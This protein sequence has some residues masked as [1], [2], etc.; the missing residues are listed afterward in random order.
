MEIYPAPLVIRL[1]LLT[2]AIGFVSSNAAA[3]RAWRPVD[4]RVQATVVR[5]IDTLFSGAYDQGA[6][7]AEVTSVDCKMRDRSDGGYVVFCSA[8]IEVQPLRQSAYGSTV[9]CTALRYNVAADLKSAELVDGGQACTDLVN[10]V[11]GQ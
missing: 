5:E 7:E 9:C 6:G 10:S 11:K 8:D 3:S 4:K 2:V 1:A